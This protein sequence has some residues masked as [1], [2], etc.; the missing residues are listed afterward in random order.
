MQLIIR[1]LILLNGFENQWLLFKN[2]LKCNAHTQKLLFYRV[3]Y[4]DLNRTINSVVQEVDIDV[5]LTAV[6]SVKTSP[7][8][9]PDFS[10]IVHIWEYKYYLISLHFNIV[11]FKRDWSLSNRLV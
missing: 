10:L 8:C 2:I 3:M 6:F 9:N 5:D 1:K 4:F 11:S 7:A